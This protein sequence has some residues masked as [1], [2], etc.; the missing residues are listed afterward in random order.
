MKES[1]LVIKLVSSLSQTRETFSNYI[2]HKRGRLEV[3]LRL[4]FFERGIYDFF[5]LLSF[6][7]HLLDLQ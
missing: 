6:F 2:M 7:F 3:K 1:K 4:L 5:T